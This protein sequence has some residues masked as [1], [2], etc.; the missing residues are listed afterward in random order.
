MRHLG[1]M[2]ALLAMSTQVMAA[3]VSHS[4][5]RSKAVMTAPTSAASTASTTVTRPAR[6][7]GRYISDRYAERF[8]KG[9][10]VAWNACTSE[11]R[12]E[13]LCDFYVVEEKARGAIQT[14]M[15]TDEQCTSS[16]PF[17]RNG[18]VASMRSKTTS[19]FNASTGLIEFE[20]KLWRT[21]RTIRGSYMERYAGKVEGTLGTNT[22]EFTSY[23]HRGRTIDYVGATI[24]AMSTGTL[25]IDLCTMGWEASLGASGI[26]GGG[27]GSIAA[28][29]LGDML[30][31]VAA[32]MEGSILGGLAGGTLAVGVTIAEA[33]VIVGVAVGV[34][35]AVAVVGLS[36][37]AVNHFCAPETP[38]GPETPELPG[39]DV[40][41]FETPDGEG[42]D[43]DEYWGAFE[44][45]CGSE[46]VEFTEGEVI[47]TYTS[48]TCV[49][50]TCLPLGW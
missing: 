7:D 12:A 21:F 18:Y 28:V 14:L 8:V 1:L 45:E 34:T 38:E 25:T 49:E 46:T 11:L 3:R 30:L 4:A 35:A 43:E 23:D 2:L 19:S 24:M 27:I 37:L 6:H 16:R 15:I 41:E 9:T 48:R 32:L 22:Y 42:C 10:M 39:D 13:G 44:Y 26:I 20:T 33:P 50:W 36:A 29:A 31:G 47:V 5:A 40:P 17:C